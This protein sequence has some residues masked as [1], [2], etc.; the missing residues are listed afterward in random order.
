MSRYAIGIP[1]HEFEGLSMSMCGRINI[2]LSKPL[3][4]TWDRAFCL[5][6]G[7]NPASSN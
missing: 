3:T 1:F 5:A 6:T 7:Y 4:P 2:P